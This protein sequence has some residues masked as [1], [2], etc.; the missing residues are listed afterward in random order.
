MAMNLKI[1]S[2]YLSF[3]HDDSS[4]R[5]LINNVNKDLSGTNAF[6]VIVDTHQADGLK[7]SDNLKAIAKLSDYLKESYGTIASYDRFIRKTHKELNGGSDKLFKVPDN[8]DLISQYTLLISPDSLERFADFKF[9][10][11]CIVV[12]SE[13]FSSEQFK[14]DLVNIAAFAE[15]ELP[16]HFTVTA[17]GQAVLIAKAAN[18]ISRE[19]L[20]NLAIML[21]IIFLIISVLFSSIKAGL[22]AM[23]PN[24]FPII[25][26]FAAMS[27]LEIPL[28]PSTFSV[29][30]IALGVAVDDTL[31][32]MV[33]FSEECKKS[34]DND[35][36]IAQTMRHEI[37]PILGTSL[38]LIVGFLALTPAE[39]VSVSELGLLSAITIFLA[40]LA[41]LIITPALLLTLPL[42][43]SWDLLSLTISQKVMDTS[44][45]FKGLKPCEIKRFVLMGNIVKAQSGDFLMLQNDKEKFI[46][47]LLKGQLDIF[48][49]GDD[50][51]NKKVRQM[52]AGSIVGEMA[53]L[54]GEPRS[55]SVQA[56]GNV[57]VLE[58]DASTMQHISNRY[59]G[60]AV[61]IH[62]NF[63]DILIKRFSV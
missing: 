6:Y 19:I 15:Q 21:S 34:L 49:A 29:V 14:R 30:I 9:Q 33:S 1:D 38:A 55:A 24:S 4:I 58:F 13:V 48:V 59:P 61:K 35:Y 43:S 3:F 44:P 26:V 2:N 39:F 32:F 62:Q 50:G 20:I 52:E 22:L 56:V 28:S 46:L 5:Q 17:T 41:D 45:I 8:D 36:A 7:K 37:K 51:V 47:L 53:L 18:Q 16:I 42:I 63:A 40:L 23:I 25:G 31:H 54:S 27:F 57:E 12:R 11:A 10:K 60:M